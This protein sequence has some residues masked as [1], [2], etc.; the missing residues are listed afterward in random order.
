MDGVVGGS[1]TWQG[2]FKRPVERGQF[3]NGSQV[4]E[5]ATAP[6]PISPCSQVS[7]PLHVVESSA[8]AALQRLK[9]EAEEK[10]DRAIKAGGIRW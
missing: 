1:V 6:S 3:T 10:R 2:A 7:A 9:T 4:G 8:R 5:T